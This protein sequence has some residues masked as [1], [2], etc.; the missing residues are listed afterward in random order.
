[1]RALP[2]SAPQNGTTSATS[3][4]QCVQC[5]AWLAFTA[6]ACNAALL[7]T[8]ACSAALLSTTPCLLQG[9]GLPACMQAADSW[10]CRSK[11]RSSRQLSAS[12]PAKAGRRLA[13]PAARSLS[14]PSRGLQRVAAS[15]PARSP[16]PPARAAQRRASPA[17]RS[18]SPPRA[19]APRGR[20]VLKT[21][22]GMLTVSFM[23]PPASQPA[24][25]YCRCSAHQAACWLGGCPVPTCRSTAPHSQ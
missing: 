25:W 1:M 5:C 6:A 3:A 15:P 20:C 10:A 17:R 12:P 11:R 8:A 9:D 24:G 2:S 21:S 13:S 18:P 16:S 14:P 4:G 23:R 19:R 7:S 22:A